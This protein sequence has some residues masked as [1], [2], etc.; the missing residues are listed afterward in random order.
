MPGIVSINGERIEYMTKVG[1]VLGQLR[2]G[3][4]GSPIGEAYPVGAAVVDVGYTEFIPYN[5]T[6]ERMDF[7]SDGS[8]TLIGPLD[9]VP[10]KGTRS[11][12]WFTDTI[13]EGNGPCDQIEVFAAGRRMRK[14]PLDVW[15]EANGAYSPTADETLEAEFSVDGATAYIRLTAP[16]AAGTRIT[17]L[18]RVG[19]LWYDRGATTASTGVTLLENSSPIAKFIAQKTTSIP[20]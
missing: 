4:H 7:V 15:V 12:T 18:K 20:E 16:L 14:D 1:N 2:R 8:S 11:G 5:E 9:F 6:Q 3:T 10:V 17:V 13:P 19:K